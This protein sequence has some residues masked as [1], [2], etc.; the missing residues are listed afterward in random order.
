MGFRTFSCSGSLT[1]PFYCLN[2]LW[3]W[4]KKTHWVCPRPLQHLLRLTYISRSIS[5][6]CVAGTLRLCNLPVKGGARK[7]DRK[8][9]VAFSSSNI[10]TVFAVRR[11]VSWF[12]ESAVKHQIQGQ[13][14]QVYVRPHLQ[15]NAD[16]PFY[17]LPQRNCWFGEIRGKTVDGQVGMGIGEGPQH[18]KIRLNGSLPA[19]P[20]TSY[21]RRK[22]NPDNLIN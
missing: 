11:A 16:M 13:D 14:V 4:N 18:R 12:A 6:L 3:K 15:D 1:N 22:L 9:R 7:D 5:S 10:Y 20:C 21:W 19:Q 2:I 17:Y 8:K